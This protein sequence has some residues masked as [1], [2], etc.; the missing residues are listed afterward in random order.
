[1]LRQND[2]R[3]ISPHGEGLVKGVAVDPVIFGFHEGRLKVL[4][5]E[6]TNTGL[7]AL[8]GGYIQEKE[9]LDEAAKRILTMRTG[10]SAVYLEQ[11]HVFGKYDRNDAGVVRQILIGQ[12][13]S[14]A[15]EH[16]SLQRFISVGYYALVDYTRIELTPDPTTGRCEWFE[17]DQIPPLILDHRLI[18]DKA[19]ATLR[20][21]L[22]QLLIGFNLLPELFTMGDLHTLY[23]TILDKKLLSTNFQRKMLSLGILERIEKKKTGKAHKAPYLYRFKSTT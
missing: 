18:I 13:F 5:I 20:I 15:E 23:E 17:F 7:Y 1:M 11:F 9:D 3:E 22:D 14:P 16:W 12:G 8:P 19:L 4:I 10:L 2:P 6:H 21:N